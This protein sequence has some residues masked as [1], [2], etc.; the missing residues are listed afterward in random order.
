MIQLTRLSIEIIFEPKTPDLAFDL[1]G[2]EFYFQLYARNR[3]IL[4][5]VDTFQIQVGI[6][7][8]QAACL[9]TAHRNL[10][11]QFLVVGVQGIQAVNTVVLGA[12]S[13]RVTENGQRLE[14]G[15]SLHG[16]FTFHLLWLVQNQ[17]WPVC[18]NDIDGF[19]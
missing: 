19:A 18:G 6:G 3:F 2:F 17:D 11:D 5:D 7:A 9:D 12:V 4:G 10:F 8:G 15:Q 1:A 16:G 14:L 13:G